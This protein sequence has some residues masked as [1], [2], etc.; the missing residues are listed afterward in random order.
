MLD[1]RGKIQEAVANQS[2]AESQLQ[3]AKN[4]AAL[5]L[6]NAFTDHQNNLK[7][8]KLYSEEIL[9]QA[10]EIH[11]TAMKSYDAGE[12]TYLEYLQARQFLITSRNNYI[13]AVFNHFQ[14]LFRI[15][16]LTG[17]KFID[18]AELEN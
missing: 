5:K 14:S 16:E 13:N 12:L 9:P 6:K 1:Q 4:E 10:E 3:L 15:E 18:N 17:Q 11:R 8:V 2:M 7:Q